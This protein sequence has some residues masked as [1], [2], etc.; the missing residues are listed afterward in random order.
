M[1]I[2]N[3]RYVLTV[4]KT[5]S[6]T[7]AAKKLYLSPQALG[8]AIRAIEE[9]Y[10]TPL[11]ERDTRTLT[12]TAFGRGFAKEAEKC[13]AAYDGACIRISS[14]AR[15]SAGNITIACAYGVPNSLGYKSPED[16]R[17]QLKEKTGQEVDISFDELPDLLAERELAEEVCDLGLLIGPPEHREEYETVRL[18]THHLVA[19]LKEGHPL[20]EKT[21]I[22][23]RELANWPIA[24]YN[25]YYRTFHVLEDCARRQQV[26]LHYALCSPDNVLWRQKVLEGAVGIGVSFLQESAKQNHYVVLPFEEEEMIYPIEL[27]RRR[28]QVMSPAMQAL[29][30]TLAAEKET[31]KPC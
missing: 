21:S 29:W 3:M 20:A 13:V 4:M 5:G 15:Q 2:K 8:K 10:G 19:V 27:A 1:D 14:Y 30:E 24:T 18:R 23:V 28:E 11:F 17:R 6:F 9:D 26:T 25:R 7:K 22:T 16:L 12:P 31:P